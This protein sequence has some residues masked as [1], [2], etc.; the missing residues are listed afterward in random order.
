MFPI[1]IIHILALTRILFNLN[2]IW[3]LLLL[4]DLW[5]PLRF[6]FEVICGSALAFRIVPFKH[7][8]AVRFLHSR[9]SCIWD[10]IIC[11]YLLNFLINMYIPQSF[12]QFS[13]RHKVWA[14]LIIILQWYAFLLL[15][16]KIILRCHAFRHFFVHTFSIETLCEADWIF[17]R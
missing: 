3:L 11:S 7:V 5:D 17:Q 10:L 12:L 8:W 9:V 6:K 2:I 1:K 16:W 4:L 13:F 15:N 14:A